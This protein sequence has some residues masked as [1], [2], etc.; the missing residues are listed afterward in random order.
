[1][2]V[3]WAQFLHIWLTM[4][5]STTWRFNNNATVRVFLLSTTA[6]GLGLNLATAANVV[7]F[8]PNWNPSYDLQAQDRAYRMGQ[9]Q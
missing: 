2:L 6:G 8:D 4:F 3:V 1:M 9:K 7:I 5:V